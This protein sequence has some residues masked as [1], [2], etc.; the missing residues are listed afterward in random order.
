V[1]AKP[2]PE[3]QF[4]DVLSGT[5]DIPRPGLATMGYELLGTRMNDLQ[6]IACNVSATAIAEYSEHWQDVVSGRAKPLNPDIV[7]RSYRVPLEDYAEFIVRTCE[8]TEVFVRAMQDLQIEF[9]A[10]KKSY[11][12]P[13]DFFA[14]VF[15]D[16]A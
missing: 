2:S 1:N 3:Y 9:A 14:T 8:V 6:T 15:G 5:T 10:L 13:D 4:S 11:A 16:N 12:M 7:A